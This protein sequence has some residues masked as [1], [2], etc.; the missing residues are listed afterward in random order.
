MVEGEVK[1]TMLEV[2][3]MLEEADRFNNGFLA[4]DTAKLAIRSALVR[5]GLRSPRSSETARILEAASLDDEELRYDQG[6][7][8]SAIRSA[9]RERLCSKSGVSLPPG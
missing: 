6:R 8:E 1:G 5:N 7:L 3:A 9:L 2:S 4:Q